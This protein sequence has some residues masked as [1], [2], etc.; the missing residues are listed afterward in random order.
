M[1][2][3]FYFNTA[4]L[5]VLLVPEPIQQIG[6]YSQ[7]IGKSGIFES[8]LMMLTFQKISI[9]TEKPK[10]SLGVKNNRECL[11][12]KITIFGHNY[13]CKKQLF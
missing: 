11:W 3:F 4:K 8:K 9:T 5:L 6:T 10:P 1:S 12:A 13:S 7:I 2:V